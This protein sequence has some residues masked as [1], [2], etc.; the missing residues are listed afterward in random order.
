[1][2]IIADR[3]AREKDKLAPVNHVSGA[4]SLQKIHPKWFC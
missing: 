4:I 3:A 1:M 2:T